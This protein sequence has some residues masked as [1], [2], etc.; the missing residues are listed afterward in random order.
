MSTTGRILTGLSACLPGCLPALIVYMVIIEPTQLR[1]QRLVVHTRQPV[2]ELQ[3]RVARA[4]ISRDLQRAGGLK[5][6]PI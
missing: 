2:L 4:Q 3:P 1:D 6:K 5:A